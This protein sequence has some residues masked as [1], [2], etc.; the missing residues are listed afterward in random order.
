MTGENNYIDFDSALR[1]IGGN[2]GLFR[3]LLTIFQKDVKIE[4]LYTAIES[5]NLNEIAVTAHTIKGVAA[6]LSLIKLTNI[7]TTIDNDAKAG[8]DCK[9]H[10]PEL[11]E[12]YDKTIEL[13]NNYLGT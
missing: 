6:N 4:E 7:T 12:S 1:R 5:N 3:K 8:L 13:I 2:E 9:V 10:I 11:R